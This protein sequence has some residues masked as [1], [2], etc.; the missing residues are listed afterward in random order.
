MSN[1]QQGK[2]HELKTSLE[3][4]SWAQRIQG[5]AQSGLQYTAN[6]YDVERYRELSHIASEIMEANTISVPGEVRMVFDK[7]CGYATPKL[8]IRG[9]VF[10]D[11]RILLVREL[12]DGGRWTLPG[13]WVDINEPPSLA[14]EREVREEAGKIVKAVKLLAV[15]DTN[16]HGH[17]PIP[18]HSYKLFFLCELLGET[19]IAPYETSEPTFFAPHELPELSLPRVTLQ[20]IARLFVHL[21]NPSL[22]TDFD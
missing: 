12:L 10:K 19:E 18:F 14:V 15:Y 20:E 7:Q 5:I 2:N 4:L 9:T 11:G 17:P 8:D 22:P 13:G 6:P 16:Q 3:W 1:L 21:Q